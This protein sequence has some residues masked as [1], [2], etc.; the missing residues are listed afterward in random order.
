MSDEVAIVTGGCS[1]FGFLTVQGL[2]SRLHKVI[3]LDVSDLP[4]ELD[5]LPNVV[6]Y[7]CD[8]T[9]AETVHKTVSEIRRAHGIVTI[10]VNNAGESAI[11]SAL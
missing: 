6:Y 8:I 4:P 2:A 11:C 1:G 9:N 3:V 10:L 7:K 5:R